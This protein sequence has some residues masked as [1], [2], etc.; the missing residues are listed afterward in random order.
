[1]KTGLV[2]DKQKY[3]PLYYRGGAPKPMSRMVSHRPRIA[4]LGPCCVAAT[5]QVRVLA[6]TTA[7]TRKHNSEERHLG[8]SNPC[9]QSPMD[10]ESISLAAR[11]QCHAALSRT[12]AYSGSGACTRSTLL[13]GEIYLCNQ[14]VESRKAFQRGS[15]TNAREESTVDPTDWANG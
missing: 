10:F 12:Q 4:W 3:K 7:S 5:T 6:R 1:L 9:G 13:I 11:T 14:R 15:V 2:R 8:D